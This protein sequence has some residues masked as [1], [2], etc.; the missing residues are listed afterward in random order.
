MEHGALELKVL[1]RNPKAGDINY[2]M[3]AHGNDMGINT[4]IRDVIARLCYC[5]RV[6]LSMQLFRRIGW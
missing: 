6:E 3:I 4:A 5:H 2:G 1:S